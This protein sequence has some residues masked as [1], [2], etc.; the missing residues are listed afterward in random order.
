MT[1]ES[2]ANT[3]ET[4]NITGIN[5]E[6]HRG[7]I[8]SFA[9]RNRAPKPDWCRVES[10]IPKITAARVIPESIFRALFAPSHSAIAG[11]NSISSAII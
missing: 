6:Y 5:S 3:L 7:C 4:K 11:E 8:F 1:M 2:P 10:V 9:I